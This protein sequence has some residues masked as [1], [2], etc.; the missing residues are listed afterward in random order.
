MRRALLWR[1]LS[2]SGDSAAPWRALGLG[3]PLA[4]SASIFPRGLSPGAAGQHIHA[5]FRAVRITQDGIPRYLTYLQLQWPSLSPQITSTGSRKW[6]ADLLRGYQPTHYTAL[7]G[8]EGFP[9]EL[10]SAWYIFVLT[11]IPLPHSACG[12]VDHRAQAPRN[13]C[14]FLTQAWAIKSNTLLADG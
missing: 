3:A 9:E 12:R 7:R 6:W 1:A 13:Y 4:S 10:D 11:R 5:G 2:C 14:S 8:W